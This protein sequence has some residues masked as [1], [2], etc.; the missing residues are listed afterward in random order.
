MLAE[1]AACASRSDI[2]PRVFVDILAKGGGDGVILNRLRPFIESRDNSAF[3][4]SI[5]NALKDMGYYT[6]MA[7][8]IGAMHGTAEAIRQTYDFAGAAGGKQATVPEMVQILAE[9]DAAALAKA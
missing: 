3:R 2:D 4:F 8:E 9:A 6:T 7:Q 1:A 5:S